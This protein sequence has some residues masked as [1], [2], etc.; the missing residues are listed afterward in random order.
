MSVYLIDYENVHDDGLE[1][2]KALS[3][4]D[5]VVIFYGQQIK[6]IPFARHVEM[7]K[8]KATYEYIETK[9]IAKNYLDFQLATFIG[10]MIGKGETRP[11]VI[12]SKDTGFDSIVDFWKNRNINITRR[13]MVASSVKTTR[14]K[15][16]K[17]TTKKA[18][19]KEKKATKKEE[20]KKEEIKKAAPK[21]MGADNKLPE[22]Y[23]KKI[24]AAVKEDKI[25]IGHY[26]ALYKAVLKSKDKLAYNN[27]LVKLFGNEKCSAIYKH[28]K[29]I[30][31]EYKTE[32]MEG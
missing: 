11:F 7:Q 22:A 8:S 19:T 26:S 24:R 5:H 13:E 28:S 12:I 1:G 4:Q 32:T 30:F 21:K 31:E 14:A 20:P 3:N 16:Q 6:S 25:S 23:R 10:Y 2:V 29:G 15:A 17:T 27:E 9:K 18:A